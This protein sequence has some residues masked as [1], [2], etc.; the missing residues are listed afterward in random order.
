LFNFSL[1]SV[2]VIKPANSCILSC[3]SNNPLI[4]AILDEL[5]PVLESPTPPTEDFDEI[6]DLALPVL[7]SFRYCFNLAS[8]LSTKSFF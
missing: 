4:P 5:E 1:Y 2:S 7:R 8:S 6:E 3:S